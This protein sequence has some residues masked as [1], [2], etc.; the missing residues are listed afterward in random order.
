MSDTESDQGQQAQL[1]VPT[2]VPGVVAIPSVAGAVQIAIPTIVMK[3][4]QL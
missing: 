3:D 2:N 1:L 4:G